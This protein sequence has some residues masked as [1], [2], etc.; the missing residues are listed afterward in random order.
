MFGL[1]Y[2]I[3]VLALVLLAVVGLYLLNKK[4]IKK[5]DT[6]YSVYREQFVKCEDEGYKKCYEAKMDEYSEKQFHYENVKPVLAAI[7][8]CASLI[9][10]GLTPP[11]IYLPIEK[12]AELKE[13]NN[14]KVMVQEIC[15]NGNIVDSFNAAT[16]AQKYNSWLA[17][18]KASKETYGVFSSYYCL[19]LENTEFIYTE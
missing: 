19:D 5:Y 2:I 17:K 14:A 18:A 4:K 8:V 15:D 10:I 6:L 1:W 9:I 11:A 16:T 12:K 13:F 3:I 7:F